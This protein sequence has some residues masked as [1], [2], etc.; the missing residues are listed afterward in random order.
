MIEEHIRSI[1][2]EIE[3][4]NKSQE[5]D[6]IE[7]FSDPIREWLYHAVLQDGPLNYDK[8]AAIV[9][10]SEATVKHRFEEL[11]KEGAIIRVEKTGNWEKLKKKK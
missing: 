2:K 11:K 7:S 3:E 5:Q 8:Y 1:S 4:F 6:P 10:P 9:G